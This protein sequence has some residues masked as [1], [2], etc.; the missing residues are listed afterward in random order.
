MQPVEWGWMDVWHELPSSGRATA[1]QLDSNPDFD[2]ANPEH[3]S[4]FSSVIPWLFCLNALDHY[5]YHVAWSIFGQA[6]GHVDWLFLLIGEACTYVSDA[7]REVCKSL[8]VMFGLAFTW[9]ITLVVD[10]LK[11]CLKVVSSSGFTN[12]CTY[13]SFKTCILFSLLTTQLI[14]SKKVYGIDKHAPVTYKNTGSD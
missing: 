2:W 13:K 1:F 7:A 5:H 8:D 6:L 14:F 10:I 12:F 9:I 11:G 4:S 3:E